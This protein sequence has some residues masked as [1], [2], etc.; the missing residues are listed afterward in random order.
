MCLHFGK[1]QFVLLLEEF[2]IFLLIL[3]P[4]QLEDRS[5]W[6]FSAQSAW[7]M[8]TAPHQI[9]GRLGDFN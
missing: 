9:H 4:V 6:K 1:E 7:V 3:V 8:S 2:I 5:V